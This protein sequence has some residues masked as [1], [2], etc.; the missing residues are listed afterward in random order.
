MK[1]PIRLAAVLLGIG[2]VLLIGTTAA[3]FTQTLQADGSLSGSVAVA[4][5]TDPADRYGDPAQPNIVAE[6]TPDSRGIATLY[7]DQRAYPTRPTASFT[8]QAA[9]LE[10]S[11]PADLR[12]ML[13]APEGEAAWI[14]PYLRFG[15]EVDG[16]NQDPD[17]IPRS[18]QQ[19]ND[20]NGIHIGTREAGAPASQIL[21]KVWLAPDAPQ[22]AY[23]Q[24]VPV[25]VTI[26]GETTAGTTF[27]LE[28]TLQ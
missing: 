6:V 19:V 16:V 25:D 27:E 5:G 15:I 7:D 9:L 23:G 14:A 3:A 18:M 2:S 26:I 4:Q 17:G 13:S 12:A 22:A 24:Q 20:A 1:R 21:I 11:A 8:V 10:G 28:M